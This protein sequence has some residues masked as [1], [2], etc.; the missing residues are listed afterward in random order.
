MKQILHW[1]TDLS[2]NNHKQCYGF[3]NSFFFHLINFS[4][5]IATFILFTS[6]QASPY[7]KLMKKKNQPKHKSSIDIAKM[8]YAILLSVRWY[9]VGYSVIISSGVLHNPETCV[10]LYY[11]SFL[12]PCEIYTS[13]FTLNPITLPKSLAKLNT[14]LSW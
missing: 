5:K 11:F 4:V 3:S 9:V 6:K 14:T 7:I 13:S 2:W 12:H 10:C 8:K 1:L